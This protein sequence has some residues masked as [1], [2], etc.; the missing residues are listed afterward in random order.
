MQMRVQLGDRLVCHGTHRDAQNG[1]L[2]GG[3]FIW[4]V[5]E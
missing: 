2:V 5:T 4:K 1:L 3:Q